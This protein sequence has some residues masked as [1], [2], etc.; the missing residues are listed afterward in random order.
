MTDP[1]PFPDNATW[2]GPLDPLQPVAP[3]GIAG[4][5]LDYLPG[6]NLLIDA[7]GDSSVPARVLR[8]LAD[9]CDLVRLAIETRKDQLSALEWAIQ[10]RA[11]MAADPAGIARATALFRAPTPDYGWDEW[12]RLLVEDMLVL[13][14]ATIYPRRSLS[15]TVL[16]LEPIDGGTIK[17]VID[18]WGR[19][20]APP[21]PAYQQVLKGLPATGYTADELVYLPRNPR[22][23]RLYGLS[24]VEQVLLT[25][26]M[27]LRRQ[28]HKL[29]YYTEGSQPDAFFGVPPDWTVEQLK[30]YQEYWDGLMAGN[31][32][33]RRRIKFIHGDVKFVETK[34]AILKDE[35]DEWLARV[36]CYAFSVS[37]GPLVREQ[38]RATAQTQDRTALREGMA[39]LMRWLKRLVD[40]V[41]GQVLDLPGLELVWQDTVEQDPGTLAQIAVALVNAGIQTRNEARA[42]LGLG[43]LPGGDVLASATPLNPVT[44][45]PLA[46]A[47]ADWRPDEHPRQP[48]GASGGIGGQFAPK[49]GA[50]AAEVANTSATLP[51]TPATTIAPRPLDEEGGSAASDGKSPSEDAPGDDPGPDF[52]VDIMGNPT[53]FR[54]QAASDIAVGVGSTA[55][56]GAA[57][58]AVEA[59]LSALGGEAAATGRRLIQ[60]LLDDEGGAVP[61]PPKPPEDE[62]APGEEPPGI[63]HNEGPSLEDAPELPDE[64]PDGPLRLGNPLRNFLDWAAECMKLDPERTLTIVRDVANL[65]H[66]AKDY[67]PWMEEYLSPP[68]PLQELQDGVKT[69][70]EGTDVH[71][72]VEQSSARDANFPESEINGSGN[73]VRISR[74]Q[75]WEITSWYATK[76][77]N[78]GGLSPRDYLQDKSWDERRK[79]GLW[80]LREFGALEP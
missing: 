78:F 58:I 5:R 15:G 34:P 52:D 8:A 14:A 55:A 32:A 16:A 24:P 6:Q 43:P 20:P 18:D 65:L 17:R 66:W 51:A 33:E 80:A 74:I 35:F 19:T 1:L 2:F 71:H 9:D 77:K 64:K 42:T 40:R 61:R 79:V 70:R 45:V 3:P 37:P 68:K 7:R 44:S 38:N 56:A 36:V 59:A 27:A 23:H 50:E 57:Y 22:T 11:G 72:I 21:Q 31:T 67:L 53:S 46:K 4:R 76:N 69:P 75:H 25:V 29:E 63:G 54:G 49:G 62:P 41:L 30:S 48:Q 10:P 60:D 12:V 13:D 73:L 26:N 28:V 47:D 39:P